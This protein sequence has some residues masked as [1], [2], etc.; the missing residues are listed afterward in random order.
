M[1]KP[2]DRHLEAPLT[3]DAARL[4]ADG[5]PLRLGE[6]DVH[7]RFTFRSLKLLEERYGDLVKVN[8]ELQSL[9]ARAHLTPFTTLPRFVHVGLG[10]EPDVTEDDVL[11]L[12][13]ERYDDVLAALAA[14]IRV[15]FP[16]VGKAD[17]EGA[18][19]DPSP[20]ATSTTSPPSD[21]AAPEPSS[22]T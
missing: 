20:G 2:A 15:G 7:V 8:E 16:D 6:R 1:A 17:E 18:Q 4:A 22:G 19:G 14:A 9:V 13:T 5:I 3:T 11:D 21:G 12:P 10:H